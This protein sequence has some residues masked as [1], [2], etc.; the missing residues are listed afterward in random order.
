MALSDI[1]I[2]QPAGRSIVCEG[3][4]AAKPL[5]KSL[6]PESTA[7]LRYIAGD[8]DTVYVVLP[9]ASQIVTFTAESLSKLE[10]FAKR[11]CADMAFCDYSDVRA[12]GETAAHPLIDYSEGAVSDSFELGK[13]VIV[14]RNAIVKYLATTP[15]NRKFA[16][17]YAF[18]LWAGHWGKISHCA[19]SLYSVA[20]T[21][22]RKSG[23][24][25]FDYLDPSAHR[26]Q[27]EMEAA[28]TDY[29]K[30][31]DAYIEPSL[32]QLVDFEKGGSF[33]REASVVIPVRNRVRT[34]ADAVRSALSQETKFPFNVMVVDNHSTDGTTEVLRKLAAED[35]RVVHIVPERTDLGIGGCW[36][37]AADDERCG[38]FAVQLDS[39]DIYSSPH[40]L[41]RIVDCFHRSHAAMVIGSYKLVDFQLG[42]LPPGVIDHKEWTAANGRNNAL[43]I[44]GL[45]APRA[46]YTPMLREV[47]FP[48]TSYG[49]DYALG[50]A[51]SREHRLSRIFD[52]L[53]LCRRWE[54]NSDAALPQEKVNKNN[55]Y[56][57][58]LRAAE[59]QKRQELNA[60]RR[61][62]P[63]Q[64]SV[65]EFTAGQLKS[66]GDAARRFAELKK[67][68]VN[69]LVCGGAKIS[70]QFNPARIV[71]TGAKVDKK[72]VAARPCFLCA[73][74]RPAEQKWLDA[75]GGRF[76]VLINPF[77]ILRGHL[78]IAS[79]RH[80]PQRIAGGYADLCRMAAALPGYVAFY[81]GPRCGASAPDHL[82]F[83]AGKRGSIPI[84]RDWLAKYAGNLKPLAAKRLRGISCVEGYACPALAIVADSEA[85]SVEAF[86]RLYATLRKSSPREEFPM[87]I[88]AWREGDELVSVVFLRKKHRPDCYFATDDSRMQI[89]PGA[90]DMGGLI[91]A[92]RQQDFT[93]INACVASGILR[94]VTLTDEETDKILDEK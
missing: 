33:D 77:P 18:R 62:F 20:E 83:Q 86:S 85:E 79:S 84:E 76:Q 12:D 13:A 5:P 59:I 14:S 34:V 39:D 21:D 22:T 89:S 52:V 74:N 57:N 58:G 27:K 56:K 44:N 40:T 66:W 72:S 93:R 10:D 87:N 1:T 69:E 60:S 70:V 37:L 26:R 6:F 42:E 81:N 11:E 50:L 3:G 63:S 38:R 25:Q 29:L 61:A 30:N 47:R 16:G 46:F 82:H 48:N 71:S 67:V 2:Y 88:L 65:E 8:C 49:E 28:F 36:Q 54:G 7:A 17:F 35:E 51:F 24:K 4:M 80:E 15:R 41:Q 92:P 32:T 43:R 68:S 78:T 9:L 31:I 53:Y 91:I 73:A 64:E 90:V 75:M 19:E 45:G 23:Q 55:V 94:E